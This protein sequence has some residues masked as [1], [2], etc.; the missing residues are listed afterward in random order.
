MYMQLVRH[1]RAMA[2]DKIEIAEKTAPEKEALIL[3]YILENIPIFHDPADLLYGDCGFANDALVKT[4]AFI[5][6]NPVNIQSFEHEISREEQQLRNEFFCKGIYTSAHTCVNYEQVVKR[7]VNGIIEEITASKTN[8]TGDRLEYLNAMEIVLNSFI[9]FAGRFG[10]NHIPLN[11]ARNFP[12]ALQTIWLVHLVISISEYSSASISLGRFDQYAYDCF[13]KTD[14]QESEIWFDNFLD[15]I[16]SYGDAACNLNLG[17][18]DADGND[19]CNELSYFIARTIKEKQMPS[20]ILSARIHPK[21]PRDLF[22]TLIAPELFKIGQ[23]TFYG[24]YSCLEALKKR[25]IPEED[26]YKWAANS[27]MGLMIQ[28]Y[29]VSDMWGVVICALLPLELTLNSGVPF[30]KELYLKLQTAPC[31]NYPDFEDLYQKFIEYLHEIINFCISANRQSTERY[32]AEYPNPFVSAFVGDCIVNGADRVTDGSRYYSVITEAFALINASDSLFAIKK[33]VFDD[34]VCSLDELVLAV[35]NNFAENSEFI[36]RILTL[37]KYGDG[38][39]DADAISARLARDFAE[40]VSGYSNRKIVYAPSFHTLNCHIPAGK[41]Y[42]ASPDGRKRGNPLAKNI[43][44]SLGLARKDLTSLLRSAATIDQSEFF[45]GQPIDISL[46]MKLIDSQEGKKKIQHLLQT[47]FA[48]GGLQV[49]VNGLSADI[50]LKAIECPDNYADLIVR[51][52]GYSNFFNRLSDEV[53]SEMV[54]RFNS[55]T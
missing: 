39:A 12:E 6:D 49:Q 41:L 43:G 30:D 15:R 27:C 18:I 26:I 14:E 10:L 3:G 48:M 40:I 47:Y 42:S 5:R 29:E 23:P 16:N 32:V 34:K 13:L 1:L 53:K 19:L 46:D 7:G 20:P 11:P 8:K 52:G 33:L 55:G 28:G 36:R 21:F 45:G 22:D 4:E 31:R 38:D 37:P 9:V 44:T 35:K 25:G 50:L 51:I 54:N 2:L 17:G 24:E